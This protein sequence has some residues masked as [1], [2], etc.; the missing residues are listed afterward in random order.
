MLHQQE[1]LGTKINIAVNPARIT[2][3]EDDPAYSQELLRP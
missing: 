2:V 1:Q 3:Y